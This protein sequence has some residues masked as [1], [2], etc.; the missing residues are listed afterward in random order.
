[1]DFKTELYIVDFEG[2][3]SVRITQRE[4]FDGLPSFSPDGRTISWTSNATQQKISIFLADWDHDEAMALLKKSTP[5]SHSK[6]Q[7]N[8]TPK[9]RL[10][11][12]IEF[13]IRRTGWQSN[14]FRRNEKG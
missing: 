1:M 2:E 12:H 3:E 5:K 8:T 11:K 13:N 10:R 9:S 4:G 6:H 7:N 14:R